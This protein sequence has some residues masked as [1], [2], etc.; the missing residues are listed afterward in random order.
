MQ[1]NQKIE[2]IFDF[3]MTDFETVPQ[4]QYIGIFKDVQKTHHDQ[5]GDGVMFIFE[6]AQ[7]EYK[8][9]TVTRI[10]KPSATKSNAT[11]KLIAGILGHF[12]PGQKAD[13]RPFVGKFYNILM[14]PT[15]G[16]KTRIGQ[17][18]QYKR[19]QQTMPVRPNTMDDPFTI[20]DIPFN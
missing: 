6:I 1:N 15:Q 4:G 16:Q 17:V 13:L 20:D 8:G 12:T 10:G 18:W 19:Q 3:E 9:Q 5:W 14:E 7:G 11:G 2:S